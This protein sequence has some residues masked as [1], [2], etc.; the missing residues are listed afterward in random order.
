MNADLLVRGIS[1]LVTPQ[2]PGPRRGAEMRQLLVIEQVA[3]AVAQGRILWIG[4][5]AEWAGRATQTV[6]LGHRAVAPGLADP[7]THAVWAGD[8]LADFEARISGVPYEAILARGGGIWSTID[9]TAAAS[10]DELIALAEPRLQALMRS[11]ATVIEI[12]SG[13]GFAPEAEMRMLR[14]IQRLADGLPAR[15][16]P[17]LLIHV[18]PKSASDRAAYVSDVCQT[19]IPEVAGQ[20]LARAVDVFVEKESWSAAEAER[21]LESA[22]RHGMDT[23][24]H[25]EQFHR[26]GGLELGLR[27]KVLS[28]DH[29]EACSKEQIADVAR[30]STIATILPGVSLHLGLPPAPGRALIDAG[31]AVA[32]GTDLNPGSSPLF[33]MSAALALAI[34]LNGLTAQEALVAGTIN[35][36]CALGLSDAGRLE[37]GMLADFLVLEGSDWR[38]LVYTL[39]AN[40]VREVWIGERRSLHEI[41][42]ANGGCGTMSLLVRPEL[43]FV[44]GVF[45]P[46]RA[47]CVSDHG[48]VEAIVASDT[49]SDNVIDL[50]GKALLPGFINV[51]SHSFQ[52]LIRGKAESRA[53][54]GRDFWSWRGTMYHAAAH[55]DPQQV[56]DVARMAFLE[57]L[58]AGTTTVGEF[59]YLHTAPDGH[60]YEDPNLLAKQVIAAAQSV[61][62]RI[63]L[64]RCAYL[65]SG[66]EVPRDPGQTRFFE[67]RDVFLANTGDLLGDTADDIVRV[68]VAPH[69][70]RAVP[71]DDIREIAAWA[72][73]HRL[74]LHMHMAEQVAENEACLREYGA[75]PVALLGKAGLL[76]PDWTAI[77]A[78]HITP[79][80]IAMLADAGATIGSCPTTERNLGDGILAADTV[81]RGGVRIA[82]GSDS[83]AQIEPLEDAREL[84]YHLRLVHQQRVMLDQI[85]EQ[86]IASRLFDCATRNGARSLGVPAG[87]LERGAFADFFT[88][89]LQDVSIAGHSADDLLPMIVFGM[90]RTAIRDVAVNGRLVV[91]DG[92]H[93][94]QKEIISRYAAVHDKVWRDAA[95]REP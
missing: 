75:T 78:I 11:G 5:E 20:K 74:P 55:L 7:H 47:I 45:L 73:Q 66:F 85:G 79:D 56:Y 2:G 84:D 26:V 77:H 62:I 19:L 51:H 16:I 76:G 10:E 18:P 57:M 63:V 71:L 94:L 41:I 15:L 39:G 33:S 80:E 27:L 24:L 92:Q 12:K 86:G 70:I 59:H 29:L 21:I 17:T 82:F 65:R 3:F 37:S 87:T 53:V 91:R 83:Q 43:L 31:A 34:R 46:K 68:G 25:T 89:D 6:D 50:P 30:G 48:R 90:N 32:V 49:A 67:K 13:Y 9:A 81:Q 36:A 95:G 93:A 23:K 44:D 69:S 28:I 8:R 35:A 54:S 58:L 40:P 72:R 52:R 88:I 1:Q 22:Q 4:P 64:L 60:S 42:V 38:D 61:G 14:V